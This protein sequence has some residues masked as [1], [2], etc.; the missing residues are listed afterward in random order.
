VSK[1]IYIRDWTKSGG[2]VAGGA[3]R[4]AKGQFPPLVNFIVSE[5]VFL[6]V[7]KF[8]SKDTKFGAG[9]PHSGRNLGAKLNFCAPI[10][11]LMEISS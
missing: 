5:N 10:Y 11:P 9:H 6:V 2:V 3:G 8:P 4:E 1:L 7:G